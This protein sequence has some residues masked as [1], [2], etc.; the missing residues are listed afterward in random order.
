MLTD[1]FKGD[2]WLTST[3]ALALSYSSSREWFL[4]RSVLPHLWS[5]LKRPC[6]THA[7]RAGVRENVL[8]HLSVTLTG[9]K[10][11]PLPTLM[12]E[13]RRNASISSTGSFCFLSFHLFLSHFHSLLRFCCPVSGLDWLGLAC[14]AQ[15]DAL[16][17]FSQYAN[18]K[19]A[20]Q[21]TFAQRESSNMHQVQHCTPEDMLHMRQSH[22]FWLHCCVCKPHSNRKQAYSKIKQQ[23]DLKGFIFSES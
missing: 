14:P 17:H 22:S 1:I 18:L 20:C 6:Q 7:H 8:S 16:T 2:F 11:L 15:R 3:A 10:A 19:I 21:E 12:P 4:D 9:E 23:L 13:A 5:L